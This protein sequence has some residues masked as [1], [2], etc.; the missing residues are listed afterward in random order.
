MWP[1]TPPVLQWT[2][3]RAPALRAP[4]ITWRVPS[5]LIARVGGVGLARFAIRGGDVIDDVDAF[6][7]ARDGGRVG[8]IA[9]HER[10]AGRFERFRGGLRQAGGTHQRPHLIAAAREHA[11]EMA[12]GET[13]RAGDEDW[14]VQRRD[15]SRSLV[16]TARGA[17]RS[18]RAIVGRPPL[19]ATSARGRRSADAVHQAGVG[20][21]RA[22]EVGVAAVASRRQRR[23]GRRDADALVGDDRSGARARPRTPRASARRAPRSSSLEHLRVR[24]QIGRDDRPSRAQIRIDLQRRV[25]AG[26]AR[27]D[28]DVARLDEVRNLA[29]AGAAPCTRRC[30]PMRRGA[31]A[32][33]LDLIGL[34]ADDQLTRVRMRLLQ[35][36]DRFEQQ[37]E[38]LIR[39]E[40]A[41]VEQQRRVPARCPTAR[42]ARRGPAP[43]TASTSPPI[44][45]SISTERSPTPMRSTVSCS[46]WQIVITTLEPCDH[47]RLGRLEHLRDQRRP[48]EA[49]VRQLLR[50]ARVHV[51]EVRDAEAA[52]EPHAED[53][54]L[55]VRVD[56]VVGLLRRLAQRGHDQQHVQ[57]QLG[58]RRADRHL[59]RRTASATDRMMRRFGRS[60]SAPIG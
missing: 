35:P 13:G 49:E 53:A 26:D 30:A 14:R 48:R 9:G 6:A 20:L 31:R 60:T 28:E 16:P 33:L 32:Q 38:P 24:E 39:F 36:R 3:R 7:G 29:A 27:R 8:E 56:R 18:R 17:R 34:A 42:A 15:R 25:G 46:S 57:D 22:R 4:S 23:R 58:R 11:R 5:T 54:G 43:A 51:V 59:L 21:A 55:F 12:A 37:L 1:C 47:V 52:A 10:H 40:R 19:R 44:T 45:F 41:G 2:T 50:Q